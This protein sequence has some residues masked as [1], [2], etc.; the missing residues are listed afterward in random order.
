MTTRRRGP[1]MTRHFIFCLVALAAAGS[2]H[3][4]TAHAAPGSRATLTVDYVFESKGHKA[5][6]YDAFDW[7]VRRTVTM[8]SE[9]TAGKPAEYSSTQAPEASHTAKTT[10]AVTQGEAI[11]RHLGGGS[12]AEVQAAF[13]KC[14]DNEACQQKV[15]MQMANAGA[16]RSRQDTQRLARE[17]ESTMKS[18]SSRYQ[19]WKATALKGRYEISE[20]TQLVHADPICMELPGARCTRRERRQGSG[21]VPAA[22]NVR[23]RDA[24]G[25]ASAEVDNAKNTLSLALPIPL[26]ALPYTETVST[27]EPQRKAEAARGPRQK[28]YDFRSLR[29]IKPFTVALKGDWRNQSGEFSVNLKGEPA[30][31]GVLKVRWRFVTQ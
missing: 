18:G 4:Q 27:D 25:F 28:L 31:T 20:T 3:A 7:Q 1:A 8:V 2:A 24:A 11:A 6:K 14:G 26:N 23:S 16:A 22:Q 10:R 21:E 29:D 30:D 19:L 5:N 9:L 15:A 17:T 12:M 13:E